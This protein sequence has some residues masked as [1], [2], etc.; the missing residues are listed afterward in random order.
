MKDFSFSRLSLL[1]KIL[2]STSVAITLLFAITGWI[3]EKNALDTTARSL[4]EEVQASFQ[5]YRS[6]WQ[7]RLSRLASV[8]LILSQMS[9]V[10]AAFSTGDQATIHDTAGELWSKASE[11]NALFLVTDPRG[12]L[13]ASLSGVPESDAWHQLAVVAQA[14]KRFPEQ[15]SGFMLKEG[16][17]YQVAVTPVYV[18]SGR[19]LA[20]LD[21]LVAGYN[22]DH[23]VAQRLK[24]STGGSEFL[25]LSGDR[26][27]A[28]ST[29]YGRTGEGHCV[30]RRPYHPPHQRRRHGV[31]AAGDAA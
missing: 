31:R 30:W 8:S 27:H 20:L 13:V 3:V 12:R 25:F 23:L 28:E 2:L 1:W 14:A 24:E 18:Q 21:V 26:L 11:E 22:V 5:A 16:R 9:D 7:S 6:L 15:A 29:R 10:R 4:E 17:L 19:G